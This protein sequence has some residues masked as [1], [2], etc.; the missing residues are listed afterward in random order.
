MNDRS[1]G[2]LSMSR[3][4]VPRTSYLGE[5]TAGLT[6]HSSM[7]GAARQQKYGKEDGRIENRTQMIMNNCIS[8]NRNLEK[9][10]RLI[11]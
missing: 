9:T 3:E 11:I 4:F 2:V 8:L 10:M 7:T 6:G 5:R 1:P